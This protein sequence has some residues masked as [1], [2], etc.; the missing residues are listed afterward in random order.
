MQDEKRK[1]AEDVLRSLQRGNISFDGL[2][3]EYSED[4]AWTE[5]PDG[6]TFTFG[7]M[8]TAFEQASFALQAG[9]TSGIVES[10]LGYHI[11]MVTDRF[12]EYVPIEQVSE[13]IANSMRNERYYKFAE[14][15]IQNAFILLNTAVYDAM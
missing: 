3:R 7:E 1:N 14:P 13:S 12:T 2:M 11:I 5:Y 9:E 8:V 10:E 4:T 6:Y 15:Q